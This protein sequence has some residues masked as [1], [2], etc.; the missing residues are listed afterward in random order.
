MAELPDRNSF[1]NENSSPSVN[2][3]TTIPR[4]ARNLC[5]RDWKSKADRRT[6]DWRGNLRGCSRRHRLLELLERSV[7][8]APRRR[9]PGEVGDKPVGMALRIGGLLPACISVD[10]SESRRFKLRRGG[11]GHGIEVSRH[12]KR[13]SEKGFE[14]ESTLFG[15]IYCFGRKR[16]RKRGCPPH[17]RNASAN[18]RNFYRNR[19]RGRQ[20]GPGTD[21]R[22]F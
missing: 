4:S 12:R 20:E 15:H 5:S 9:R 10:F 7:T 1:L 13:C 8:T 17:S 22:D 18:L 3:S 2:I 16:I 21:V 14:M 6:S 11:L 19:K